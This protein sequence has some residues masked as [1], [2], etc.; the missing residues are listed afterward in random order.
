[1]FSQ[2][3]L[4]NVI[5]YAYGCRDLLSSLESSVIIL[6]KLRLVAMNLYANGLWQIKPLL[7]GPFAKT[8]SLDI[9]NA[10]P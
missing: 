2:Y 4:V 9:M 8:L 1:M 10:V 7:S 3:P 6:R 5:R